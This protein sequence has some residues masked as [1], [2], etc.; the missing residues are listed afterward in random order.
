[1]TSP[2]SFP[3]LWQVPRY[4]ALS[5][6]EIHVW[7]AFLDKPAPCVA[8]MLR[9]LSSEERAWAERF[10]FPRDRH[11]YIIAHGI[12]RAILGQYL[13][14]DPADVLVRYLPSGKPVLAPEWSGDQLQ[15]NFSHSHQVALCAVGR[16]RRVGIDVEYVRAEFAEEGIAERFFSPREVAALRALP[17]NCQAEAFFACWTRKEAYIKARGEGLR[18]PLNQFEVVVVP[19]QPAALLYDEA[20]PQAVSRWSMRS[21]DLGPAYVAALTV[22]GHGWQLH[23]LLWTR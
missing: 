7:T 6:D 23:P 14:I 19:G 1:M 20:D 4:R 11:R 3:A 12:L 21:L 5:E 2:G 15:F 17:R 9:V 8:R 13:N 18:I 16:G 22:E 10:H